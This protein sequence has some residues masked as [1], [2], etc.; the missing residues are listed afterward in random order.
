MEFINTIFAYST[1]KIK[2][3]PPLLYSSSNPG[4]NSDS[5]SA[6]SK[7]VRIVSAKHEVT[8]TFIAQDH[9]PN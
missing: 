1:D 5:P 2:A 9:T 3:N 4:T 7:G 8:H 6:T